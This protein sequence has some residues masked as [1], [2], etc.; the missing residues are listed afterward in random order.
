MRITAATVNA[1]QR[2]MNS[3]TRG[4]FNSSTRSLIMNGV[5]FFLAQC[6]HMNFHDPGDKVLAQVKNSSATSISSSDQG[7]C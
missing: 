2:Y 6:S 7:R 3:D 1:C 4:K 5:G